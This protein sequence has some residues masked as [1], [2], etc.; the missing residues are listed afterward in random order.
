MQDIYEMINDIEIDESEFVEIEVDE[1]EVKRVKNFLRKNIKKS[2]KSRGKWIAAASI[3]STIIIT[4]GISF[5]TYAKQI[6]II[7][8]I[9]EVLEDSIYKNYKENANEINVTKES[10]GVSITVNDAIFDGANITLT[11][12]IESDKDLGET[13][14]LWDWVKIK[15]YEHSGSTT[16]PNFIKVADN[17]Y[18]GQENINIFDLVQNPRENI[19]FTLGINGIVNNDDMSE[20][21][22]KWKFDISL[23]ATKGET[24]VVSKSAEKEGVTATIDRL[25]LNPMSTFLAFSQSV[26]KDVREK[27]DGIMMELEVKDDLGN[28]YLSDAHGSTGD[29][30]FN[31]SSSI[32]MEKVKEGASQLIIT[33][34]VI[35]KD[36]GEVRYVEQESRDGKTGETHIGLAETYDCIEVKELILDDI[37]VYLNKEIQ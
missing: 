6:P 29:T 28:I 27:Y 15:G 25:T 20:I 16:S 17:T 4:L 24:I 3:A 19:E 10:N 11:Y 26:S 1:V 34:K 13:I 37:V 36:L 14:R 33:P 2:N 30:D 5:P 21:K 18:V 7:G 32:T 9:F 35:L 8:N 22:G 23:E 12:T 31:L